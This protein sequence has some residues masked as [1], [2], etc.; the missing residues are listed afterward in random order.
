LL[1]E[2]KE[3]RVSWERVEISEEEGDTDWEKEE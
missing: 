1:R 2:V 3:S